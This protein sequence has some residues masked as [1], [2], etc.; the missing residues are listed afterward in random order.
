MKDPLQQ[1]YQ[2]IAFGSKVFILKIET[3]P[4]PSHQSPGHSPCSI[5]LQCIRQSKATNLLIQK[6]LIG[7]II[8]KSIL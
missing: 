2:N 1:S 6:K 7:S 3:H 4:A 8:K 5:T